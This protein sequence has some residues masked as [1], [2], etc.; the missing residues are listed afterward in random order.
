MPDSKTYPIIL[1]HGIARLDVLTNAVFG[2]DNDARADYL[3][4]FRNIRTFLEEHGF[5]VHHTNVSF[6]GSVAARSVDLKKQ[7]DKILK[8]TGAKKLYII[9][10]SMGGLDTRRMLWDNRKDKFEENIMSLTTVATPHHGSPFADL[11]SRWFPGRFKW[12]RTAFGGIDDLTTAATAAFNDE[13][14]D[15]EKNCKVHFRAY[16]GS[17]RFWKIV[18]VLKFS[19][20]VIRWKEGPNDGFVSVKSARWDDKYFVEPVQ[21]ADHLNLMGWWDP[22]EKMGGAKRKALENE[23]KHLYLQ[24]A[25]DLADQFPL[26]RSAVAGPERGVPPR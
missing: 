21:E 16:A 4:Y 2:I 11:V 25:R 23:I 6:A 17:Q 14:G 19:W 12:L 5:D 13:A 8:E 3:H 7:V 9:A 24:I 1:A 18:T 15:W 22:S 26:P 20:Q 10:H